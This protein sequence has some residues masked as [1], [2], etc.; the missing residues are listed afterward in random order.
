MQKWGGWLALIG[1]GSFV[2]HMMNMEFIVI[3]WIDH[4]GL[5][6]GNGIR[7]AMVVVGAIMWFVGRQQE[8]KPAA[9]PPA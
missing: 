9:P 6:I 1:A 8:V 3:S 5:A 4:W 7:V 2:L